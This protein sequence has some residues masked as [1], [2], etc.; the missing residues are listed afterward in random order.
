[1]DDIKREMK[2]RLA[3]EGV[4]IIDED[5]INILI[6]VIS[7]WIKEN[8]KALVSDLIRKASTVD[9]AEKRERLKQAKL[10]TDLIARIPLELTDKQKESIHG[11]IY[12]AMED[13]LNE[14]ATKLHPPWWKSPV[15]I[16]C[17][18]NTVIGLGILIAL[19]FG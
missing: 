17:G 11:I 9:A 19:G 14:L 3:D 10:T 6:D 7:I 5:P 18:I 16:L 12:S 15:F 4:L 13:V 8:N 2:H 1:M